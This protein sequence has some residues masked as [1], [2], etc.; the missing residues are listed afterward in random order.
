MRATRF[1]S[2]LNRALL[3]LA[4]PKPVAERQNAGKLV[5]DLCAAH[6]L[7]AGTLDLVTDRHR[8]HPVFLAV[9]AD[10]NRTAQQMRPVADGD[11]DEF[12]A[13]QP[14]RFFRQGEAHFIDARRNRRVLQNFDL[15][16]LHRNVFP[17]LNSFYA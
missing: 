2:S 4:Q 5:A 1:C 17:L 16:F 9:L 10:R 15:L 13:E 12:T 11:I 6:R 7:R 8:L 3:L 14:V